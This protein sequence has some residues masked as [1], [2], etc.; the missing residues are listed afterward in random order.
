M[1]TLLKHKDNLNKTSYVILLLMM[2]YGSLVV[3]QENPPIPVEVDVNTSRFL[4]F[5]S[6]ITGDSGGT[7]S[8]D[9]NSIR[10]SSGDIILLNLGQTVSSALFEV[11]VNPGT[12]ISIAPTPAIVMNGSNGGSVTLNIDSYSTGSTFITTSSSEVINDVYI[13][14]TLSVGNSTASPAGN[15][16]GTFTITFIQQ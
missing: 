2:F 8:V 11:K 12:I 3:A 15:Y 5:G 10:T 1:K 13:G 14:G 7:V 4:N 9:Y 16:N 6:F